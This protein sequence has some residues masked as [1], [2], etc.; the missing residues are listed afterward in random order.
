MKTRIIHYLHFSQTEI[1]NP[2][3]T[4]SQKFGFLID[5]HDFFH[6]NHRPK[7]GVFIYIIAGVSTARNWSIKNDLDAHGK[8]SKIDRSH[9]EVLRSLTKLASSSS[10]SRGQPCGRYFRFPSGFF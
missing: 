5:H 2:K 6:K 7:L 8:R 1:L 4:F 9:S 3:A 10:R